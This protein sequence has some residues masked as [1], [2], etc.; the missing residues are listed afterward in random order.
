MTITDIVIKSH[1]TDI[2]SID[3]QATA[4]VAYYTLQ[5]QRVD[6]P[7]KGIYI[8]SYSNGQVIKKICK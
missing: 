4:P 8:V 1:T 5:G 3:Q 6:Y 7:G 2:N